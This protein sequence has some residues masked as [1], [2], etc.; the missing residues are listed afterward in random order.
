MRRLHFHYRFA[1]G[2]LALSL[3]LL[4]TGVVQQW[5]L[6]SAARVPATSQVAGHAC[7]FGHGAGTHGD[8]EDS[9]PPTHD[10]AKCQVCIAVHLSSKALT[11]TLAEA[12]ELDLPP[13]V[14]GG[15]AST[16]TIVVSAFLVH[17]APRAPPTQ[18]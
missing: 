2:L 12:I 17:R 4:G 16:E 9:R 3:T 11:V 7:D 13:S 5:H 8:R 6:A 1:G 10:P 18:L 14:D 15:F